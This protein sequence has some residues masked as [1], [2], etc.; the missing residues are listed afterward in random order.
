MVINT[1]VFLILNP[2]HK[3]YFFFYKNVF[4]SANFRLGSLRVSTPTDRVPQL[5]TPCRGNNIYFF[6]ISKIKKGGGETVVNRYVGE[7]G[8]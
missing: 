5:K 1:G 2:D 6:S 4:F 7:K 3:Q 8:P